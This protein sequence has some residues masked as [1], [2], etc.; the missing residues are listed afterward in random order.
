MLL[1]DGV[2][3]SEILTSLVRSGR[4]VDHF[5]RV[6]APMEDVFVHAVGGGAP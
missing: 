2:V 6:L 1:D 5:E 3:P 4:S